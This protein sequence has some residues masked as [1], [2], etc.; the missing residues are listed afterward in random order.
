MAQKVRKERITKKEF[1][2]RG[3]FANSNL[4]RLQ[5]RGGS[6]RYYT[7]MPEID[8]IANAVEAGRQ[9]G[10]DILRKARDE[11]RKQILGERLP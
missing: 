1:Y 11:G 9:E 3:G 7:R 4:F 5:T 6:W 10:F 2:D 8:Q